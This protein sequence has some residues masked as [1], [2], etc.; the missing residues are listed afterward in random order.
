MKKSALLGMCLAAILSAGTLPA[1][2]QSHSPSTQWHWN[3]GKIMIDSPER[4]AGQKDVIGLTLPK[5]KTVRVGFVGLGMRGPDAVADFAL[6][7]GVEI[8][9]LCDF[10]ERAQ[11]SSTRPCASTD[12]RPQPSIRAPR[13]TRRSAAATT[14]TSSISPQTGSTMPS[15]HDVRWSTARTW[16]TRCH[17]P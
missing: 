15:W 9:A 13:A 8:V 16:P 17:R 2:A 6:L 1:S 3:K 10:E 12:W 7:P 5:M 4:P 14:S 11:P